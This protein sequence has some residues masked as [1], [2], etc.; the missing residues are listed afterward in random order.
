ML[1]TLVGT[2]CA[3]GEVEA[4]VKIATAGVVVGGASD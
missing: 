2:R 1:G 3:S 4:G